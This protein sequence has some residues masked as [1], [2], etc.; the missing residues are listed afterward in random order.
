MSGI[1]WQAGP[2]TTTPASMTTAP[3]ARQLIPLELATILPPSAV[4]TAVTATLTDLATGLDAGASGALTG[5]GLTDA[6]TAHA[7]LVNLPAGT[8]RLL[9]LITVTG[10]DIQPAETFIYSK[11]GGV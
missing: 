4:A 11:A 5:V 2:I 7:T 1:T 10:G 8:Y 9:W 6:D 3:G